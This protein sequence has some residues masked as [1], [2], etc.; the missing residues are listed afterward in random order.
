MTST[1]A[2]LII[3]KY[4][5]VLEKA[6]SGDGD[7]FRLSQLPAPPQKI[8]Q[9]M[10]LSLANDIRNGAL[11]EHRRNAIGGGANF[12]TRFIPDDEAQRLNTIK[13]NAKRSR[14]TRLSPDEFDK[15]MQIMDEIGN[16]TINA[17]ATGL[18]LRC[19]ITTFIESVQQID[20]GDPLFWQRVY[21][22]AG[23]EY[24]DPAKPVAKKRSFWDWCS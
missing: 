5:A 24:S 8:M 7:A 2:E 6:C 23:L 1:Q 11:T 4:G 15:R 12:L 18:T 20:V 19:E 22:F 3:T 17:M 10:K 16:W 13:R 9:A 14:G 21:T